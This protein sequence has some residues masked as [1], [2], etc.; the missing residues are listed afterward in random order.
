MAKLDEQSINQFISHPNDYVLA[1]KG[2]VIYAE[3]KIGWSW[4]K[5]S[6]NKEAYELRP[7]VNE[8][9][10]I[11]NLKKALVDEVNRAIDQHN[12]TCLESP[13]RIGHLSHHVQ[14]EADSVHIAFDRHGPARDV[15]QEPR[16]RTPTKQDRRI[17]PKESQERIPAT[18]LTTFAELSQGADVEV[19]L[20][21]DAFKQAVAAAYGDNDVRF[22]DHISSSFDEALEEIIGKKEGG[23][24]RKISDAA[25]FNEKLRD[26]FFKKLTKG[27]ILDRAQKE[28]VY[29]LFKNQELQSVLERFFWKL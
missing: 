19:S 20:I 29:D 3:K 27:S 10:T 18:K 8:L 22:Q 24:G 1:K 2:D 26:L 23:R 13:K 12:T 21:S 4:L 16:L 11:E 5:R 25:A 17:S 14:F 28:K 9:K 6:L 15:Q 7:I